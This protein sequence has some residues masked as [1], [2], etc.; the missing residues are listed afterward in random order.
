[1]NK[2]QFSKLKV[3]DIVEYNSSGILV[4]CQFKITKALNNGIV[5]GEVTKQ[6]SSGSML[7]SYLVGKP[8]A[9][10]QE[11]LTLVSPEPV[12]SEPFATLALSVQEAAVL[13]KLMRGVSGCESNSLRFFTTN[14]QTK[15]SNKFPDDDCLDD[16]RMF[17][18]DKSIYSNVY[19]RELDEKLVAI[20]LLKAPEKPKAAAR[21]KLK[22]PDGKFAPKNYRRVMYPEHGNGKLIER[23]ILLGDFTNGTSGTNVSVQEWDGEEWQPKTYSAAKIKPAKE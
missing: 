6:G 20:G 14:I 11:N 17:E 5:E 7:R 19:P 1:M 2:E 13:L 3:G 23:H 21:H 9:G 8:I 15:L 12:A 4:G 16:Y 22:G 10:A 18:Y